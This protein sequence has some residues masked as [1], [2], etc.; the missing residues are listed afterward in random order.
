MQRNTILHKT[1]YRLLVI[2]VFGLFL[3]LFIS[4]LFMGIDNYDVRSY[5]IIGA[6]TLSGE[7]IYP[8]WASFHHPYFPFFLYIEALAL[9][10]AMMLHI[11][12]LFLLKILFSFFDVA[13]IYMVYL[14]S[15]KNIRNAL[16]YAINPITILITCLHGQFDAIP[17]FF[18]LTAIYAFQRKEQ[19][20]SMALLSVG[21]L[22]KP[23]PLM[24]FY[25]FFTRLKNKMNIFWMITIP[26]IFS[27][28]YFIAFKNSLINIFLPIMRYR[29]I[30]GYSGISILTSFLNHQTV[31]DIPRHLIKV[32]GIIYL[33]YMMKQNKGSLLHDI[34]NLML[35]Y[36]VFTPN[37]SPQ[38]FLRS[39][40]FLLIIKPPLWKT[41]II[42]I[43]LSL[44]PLYLPMITSQ[45]PGFPISIPGQLHIDIAT[46]LLTWV[47]LLTMFIRLRRKS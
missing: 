44:L 17:L 39:V 28:I 27:L 7:S 3:R 35:F 4:M 9:K 8:F 10:S 32:F 37:F 21:I 6:F 41:L 26:V 14:L 5:Q 47:T 18:L 40:P 12:Q 33:I 13:T 36:Y 11:P 16:Y 15:K 2:L 45:Y 42:A 46:I 34:F 29:S 20:K 38:Y 22:M 31:I 23:W 19:W 1:N 43:C 30:F 24:F 25:P